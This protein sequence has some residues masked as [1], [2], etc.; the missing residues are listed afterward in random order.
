MSNYHNL[1][2]KSLLHLGQNVITFRTLLHLGQNVIKFRTLLHLG[3]FIT[4]RPST[5]C[6]CD[7][8]AVP[9]YTLN[10]FR[11]SSGQRRYRLNIAKKIRFFFPFL[12]RP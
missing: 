9:E 12:A 4:F 2:L 1:Q 3:S 11:S 6:C 5:T 7:L 10:R 8:M